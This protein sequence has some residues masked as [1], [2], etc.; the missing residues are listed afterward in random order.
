MSSNYVNKQIKIYVDIDI[1]VR[2][3]EPREKLWGMGSSPVRIAED[4]RQEAFEEKN[5]KTSWKPAFFHH[6]FSKKNLFRC[7]INAS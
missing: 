5:S 6:T 3:C 1:Y 7:A 4:R 2:K